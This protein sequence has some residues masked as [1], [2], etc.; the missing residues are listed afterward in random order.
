MGDD[1]P[2]FQ[3]G[4]VGDRPFGAVLA[5]EA[6]FFFFIRNR[7]DTRGF[8]IFICLAVAQAYPVGCI[9]KQVGRDS[10][11]QKS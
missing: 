2:G 7:A 1:S 4:K 5:G 11:E 10:A 9:G 8:L 6:F 3:D